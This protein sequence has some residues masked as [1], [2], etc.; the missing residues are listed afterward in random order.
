MIVG[1]QHVARTRVYLARVRID[2]DGM[3]WDGRMEA[4]ATREAQGVRG[5]G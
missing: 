5:D 1:A 3:G 2:F 4:T